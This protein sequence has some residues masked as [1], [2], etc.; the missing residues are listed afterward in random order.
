[1]FWDTIKKKIFTIS[2]FYRGIQA[3]RLLFTFNTCIA[4]IRVFR[5]SG[6]TRIIKYRC[7]IAL[8]YAGY[9]LGRFF[10]C[11]THRPY[12]IAREVTHYSG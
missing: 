12:S 5:L 4:T 11:R 6:I 8:K 10:S 2:F 1:M 9:H 3:I 7:W